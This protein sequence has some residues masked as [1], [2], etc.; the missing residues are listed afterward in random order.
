M[1]NLERIGLEELQELAESYANLNVVDLKMA[2]TEDE[3]IPPQGNPPY[4]PRGFN[5]REGDGFH[6]YEHHH[7]ETSRRAS[8]RRRKIDTT[9]YGKALLEPIHPYGLTLNLDD[10]D[11]KDREKLI[12]DWGVSMKISATTLEWEK[13]TFLRMIQ[14]SFA[15]I[16]KE[17]FENTSEEQMNI[18]WGVKKEEKNEEGEIIQAAEDD[19][20][21]MAITE[22]IVQCLKYT[23]VGD[24]YYGLHNTEKKKMYLQAFLNLRLVTLR[25]ETLNKFLKLFTVYLY[26]SG[27][28]EELAKNF[29]S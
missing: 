20:D 24:G 14:L 10:A 11:F 15:G 17:L 6:T 27:I 13:S 19:Q 2:K 22:R 26:R 16:V 1:S 28:K 7:A 4:R 29:S 8:Q 25:Q 12:D 9:P 18:F 21:Y 3:E 23:Y 5:I